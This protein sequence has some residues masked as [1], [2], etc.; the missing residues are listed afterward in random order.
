MIELWKEKDEQQKAEL[1]SRKEG[2]YAEQLCAATALRQLAV[3]RNGN[4]AYACAA[5]WWRKVVEGAPYPGEEAGTNDTNDIAIGKGEQGE[6]EEERGAAAMR[7]AVAA[8]LRELL[9]AGAQA[10]VDEV[11]GEVKDLSQKAAPRRTATSELLCSLLQSDPLC[12]ETTTDDDDAAATAAAA[13]A[14]KH[15][16]AT[17]ETPA[18]FAERLQCAADPDRKIPSPRKA[19]AP[20]LCASPLSCHPSAP[21]TGSSCWLRCC[22]RLCICTTR[23]TSRRTAIGT[24]TPASAPSGS[25]ARSSNQAI[26]STRAATPAALT[27]PCDPHCG[28]CT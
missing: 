11:D 26:C 3:S 10:V 28:C 19:G 14:R 25:R 13:A 17:M 15:Y 24:T 23:S 4:C 6:E 7:A 12:A 1:A 21:T 20:R 22:A 18:I 8:K 5:R 27:R 9:D 16:V 2:A